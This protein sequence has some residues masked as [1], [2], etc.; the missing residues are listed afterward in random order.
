MPLSYFIKYNV[1]ILGIPIYWL[2]FL[3]SSAGKESAYNA[4]DHCLNPGSGKSPA[5]VIGYPLQYS[6]ASM[7][8]QMVKNPSAMWETWVWSLGW[9]DPLESAIQSALYLH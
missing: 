2:G 3:G 5:E 7:V 6:W 8:A 4:G 9:E 1:L